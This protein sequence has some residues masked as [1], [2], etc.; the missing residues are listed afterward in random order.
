[1]EKWIEVHK[2]VFYEKSKIEKLNKAAEK[3]YNELERKLLYGK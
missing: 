3:F 2:G 1:M